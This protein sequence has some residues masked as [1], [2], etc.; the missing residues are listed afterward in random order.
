VVVVIATVLI[1]VI[2]G[3]TVLAAVALR[4]VYD[5]AVRAELNAIGGQSDYN[6]AQ[7]AAHEASEAPHTLK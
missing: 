7:H 6:A 4:V 2:A 3:L 1:P 5:I